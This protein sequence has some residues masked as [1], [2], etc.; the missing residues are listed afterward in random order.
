MQELVKGQIDA[1]AITLNSPPLNLIVRLEATS[2]GTLLAQTA[3]LST[4]GKGW[5]FQY[6]GDFGW[7]GI[8]Q[9][10]NVTIAVCEYVTAGN[11]FTRT[12]THSPPG[13]TG[14]GATNGTESG[15]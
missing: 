12:H 4:P 1:Q 11:V 6:G 10:D 13:K 3:D 7:R 2:L 15:I 9:L 5:E 14:G 8:L